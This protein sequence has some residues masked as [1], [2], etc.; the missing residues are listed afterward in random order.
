MYKIWR[1]LTHSCYFV[2]THYNVI[3]DRKFEKDTNIIE[4]NE[5]AFSPSISPENEVEKLFSRFEFNFQSYVARIAV[6]MVLRFFFGF[7]T[8]ERT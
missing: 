8:Y 5:K 6:I 2:K 4:L 7:F 1:K 3:Q